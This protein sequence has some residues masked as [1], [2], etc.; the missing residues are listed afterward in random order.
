MSSF[1]EKV[2]ADEALL[3]SLLEAESERMRWKLSKRI[4]RSLQ[5]FLDVDDV[6]QQSCVDA[7]YAIKDV[8][9]EDRNSFAAWFET[10]SRRNL[11]DII[12]SLKSLKRGGGRQEVQFHSLTMS[13]T[14]LFSQLS[15]H[16]VTA[17]RQVMA[18]EAIDYLHQAIEKLPEHYRVVVEQYDL[19]HRK[20]EQ[21]AETLGKSVGAT[22][23]IRSRAHSLL[24]QALGSMSPN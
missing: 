22:F 15:M 14:K 23:M 1:H 10:I 11:I 12:R 7:F 21:I 8:R 5:S 13:L 24:L 6:L 16:S 4:P 3:V 20:I 19:Q 9:L 2:R 17:S 18:S